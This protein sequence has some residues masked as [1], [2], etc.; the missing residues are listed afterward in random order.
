MDSDLALR[1]EQLAPLTAEST[2]DVKRDFKRWDCS[3]CKSLMIMKHSISE[4]FKGIESE[5][6]TQAKVSLTK[7]RTFC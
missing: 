2:P 3:N 7:L 6:I 4:A 5:K 1:E